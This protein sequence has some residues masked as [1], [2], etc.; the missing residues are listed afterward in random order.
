MFKRLVWFRN[1]LRVFDNPA[2]HHAAEDKQGVLAVYFVC[3]AMF[4]AHDVAPVRID[5]IRRTLSELVKSLAQLHIPL[6][7]VRINNTQDI[8]RYCK[9]LVVD[10]SIE[11]LCLNAEYPIDEFNRD[12]Q[13]SESL[14]TQGV[15]VKRFHDRVIIPPGMIRNG[16][17]E[18]YKVFTAFKHNWLRQASA[19]P[20]QPLGKPARQPEQVFI[21]PD[22]LQPD[23]DTLLKK[24]FKGIASRDLSSLWPAGEKEAIK[25]LGYF[26]KNHI[27]DYQTARDVPSLDATSTLSPYLAMGAISPR[28]CIAAV[29]AETHGEW[30]SGNSGITTWIS[31][32]VWRDFYQHVVVDFPQVCK[33]KPMQPYTDAFPWRQDEKLFIAWCE[34]K[35]GIPIIDAAMLQLKETGWMHNRLRMVV[36]MFLTKNLQIDWRLGERYFM[37]QLIDGDFSANNGGWQWSASTGTD[38][39]PYFRIF[40]PVSQSQRFDENGDFIRRYLP[41]LAH[42]S[43]KQI[44]NPPPMNNYPAPIVDLSV[45]RKNTIAL[46]GEIKHF[47]K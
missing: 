2:L 43:A 31:E 6:L 18:P 32:L 42:L 9:K 34:G 1:D 11:T 45:S 24:M 4:S 46:F 40:N 37:S 26:I 25:R 41:V 17:G 38:A 3:P 23:D 20:L 35:T 13:V 8:I 44:H 28:Q 33:H 29:L 30:D 47:G 19:L 21:S 15:T 39:A 5:F 36:A 14:R 10:H 27:A 7:I 16:S 22:V 12:K